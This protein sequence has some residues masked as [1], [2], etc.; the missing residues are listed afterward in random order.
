MR[1]PIATLG[2]AAALAL[3]CVPQDARADGVDLVCVQVIVGGVLNAGT[4]EHCVPTP[5]PTTELH[6][7]VGHQPYVWIVVDVRHP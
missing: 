6:R 4:G 7:E 3:A 2:V 1:S 5:F